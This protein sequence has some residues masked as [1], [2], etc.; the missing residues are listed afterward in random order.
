MIW[1]RH[2]PQND[3]DRTV[4]HMLIG[5][6]LYWDH[7]VFISKPF[8]SLLDEMSYSK[9]IPRRFS[10]PKADEVEYLHVLGSDDQEFFNYPEITFSGRLWHLIFSSNSTPLTLP[11]I[12]D[13]VYYLMT[14]S[15]SPNSTFT[16]I[17][18][19][20]LDYIEWN[21]P[22]RVSLKLSFNTFFW[23]ITWYDT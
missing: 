10:S 3:N 12:F 8:T 21:K 22:T 16:W 11:S 17:L 7:K 13:T 14:R 18:D 15:C 2:L 1:K 9:R 19:A 23:Q 4:I 5:F 6:V 20:T